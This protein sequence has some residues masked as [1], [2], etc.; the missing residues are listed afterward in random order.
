MKP[1]FRNL[2]NYENVLHL[3]NVLMNKNVANGFTLVFT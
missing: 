3:F 1:S 2:E